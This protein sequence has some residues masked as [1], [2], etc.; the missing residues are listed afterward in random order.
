MW[1]VNTHTKNK[2]SKSPR[3]VGPQRK[4]PQGKNMRTREAKTGTVNAREVK[5]KQS[6]CQLSENTRNKM[7]CLLHNNILNHSTPT[8]T[9]VIIK[10]IRVIFFPSKFVKCVPLYF[11][12]FQNMQCCFSNLLSIKTIMSYI[13]C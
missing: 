12:Y 2:R 5:N 1:S 10:K 11:G 3:S 8:L 9:Y 13:W 6:E 4:C 7:K